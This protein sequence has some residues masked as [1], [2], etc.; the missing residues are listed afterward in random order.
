MTH[1]KAVR[2]RLAAI[3][4]G[5]AATLSLQAACAPAADTTERPFNPPVGSRWVIET[6]TRTDEMRAEGGAR[7]SL[8]RT[9]AELSIDEK[10]A[11]GFRITYVRRGTTA[12][13]NDPTLPM[14]RS[15]AKALDDVPIKATTDR[16]GKPVRVDNLDEARAALRAMAGRITEPFKDKPQLVTTL[17]QIMAG[18]IEADA[19]KAAANYLEELPQLAKAQSTGMKLHEVRRTSDAVDN[20]LG[21]GAMKS[22]S[23]FELTAADS[24]SGKR[25]YVNTTAYDPASLKELMQSLTR[26]LMVAA[27][28]SVTPQEIDGIVKQ[29]VL[30]LDARAEFSVEDGMTRKIADTTVTKAS[31]LGRSMQKTE[32]RTIVVTAAP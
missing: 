31:A 17:N 24:A 3:F 11:D 30:S 19:V 32:N 20:P 1:P 4:I 2:L 12:E 29:M 21:G 13:G 27:G 22:N 8:I 9:R 15:A 25:S 23:S 16:Q 10:V 7:N 14:V 18:L 5:A 26:K 28:N 6:E